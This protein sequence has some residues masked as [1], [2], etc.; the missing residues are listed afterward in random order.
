MPTP[1]DLLLLRPL[2][3]FGLGCV[4]VV[5]FVSARSGFSVA[6]RSDACLALRDIG[7]RIDRWEDMILPIIRQERRKELDQIELDMLK[8]CVSL[9]VA[10]LV[11]GWL[12]RTK[13]PV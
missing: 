4:V 3:L 12:G 7:A 8:A 11:L 1:D 13:H 2:A 5:S 10:Y 9:S 6:I